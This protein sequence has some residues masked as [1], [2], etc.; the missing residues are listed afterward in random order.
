MKKLFLLKTWLLLCALIVGSGTM[1][2]TTSTLTFTKAC[3]GSG[4]ADDKTAWT[5]TS[6]AAESDYSSTKGIHYGTSKV[7]VSYLNLTTSG[8]SGTITQIVVNASGASG[9]SAKLNVTVGGNAFGSEQSL[10]SNATNYTLT[11]SASGTIVVAVTQSSAKKALYVKSITVTYSTGTPVVSA[12][13]SLSTTD[14]SINQ[15]DGVVSLSS[16]TLAEGLTNAPT[17]SWT[18][19]SSIPEGIITEIDGDNTGFLYS[20]GATTGT[21]VIKLAVTTTEEGYTNF[22]KT[23]DVNVINPSALVA[24]TITESTSFLGS[25]YSVMSTTTEGG[26]IKYST[27]GGANWLDYPG[28]DGILITETT[29]ITAKV[30]KDADESETVEATYT[31]IPYYENIAALNALEDY[32]GETEYV[33]LTNA[34][35]VYA[36]GANVFIQDGTSADCGINLY[37]ATSFGLAEGDKING[38]VYGT[39]A[40]QYSA[41]SL[42]SVGFVEG[43]TKESGAELPE[44]TLTSSE[45]SENFFNYCNMRVALSNVVVVKSIS[46][47]T[48]STDEGFEVYN[49]SEKDMTANTSYR[50]KG[51]CQIYSGNNRIRPL[52]NSDL[53]TVS[54]LSLDK[55][56]LSMTAGE[57]TTLVATYTPSNATVE[58]TT[59][60]SAVAT[61]ENG[62]IT[63]IASG[64]AT[65]TATIAD[66]EN[67]E[68][69][70]ATCE[71][72]IAPA[73]ATISSA[74][75]AATELL[76]GSTTTVTPTVVWNEDYTG[77]KVIT[78]QPSDETVISVDA[79]GNIK[80]LAAGTST[81][82]VAIADQPG[83]KGVSYVTNEITV[84]ALATP[85]FTPNGG[86][87]IGSTSVEIASTDGDAVNIYYSLDGSDPATLYS[88]PI[89]VSVGQTVKAIAKNK[90]DETYTS[91]LATSE[92]FTEATT[93]IELGTS[94]IVIQDF[95]ALTGTYSDNNGERSIGGY[96]WNVNQCINLNNKNEILQLRSGSGYISTYVTNQLG[97]VLTIAH[98]DSNIA[99]V[100][101]GGNTITPNEDSGNTRTYTIT[102]TSGELKIK[103]NGAVTKISSI[104]LTPKSATFSIAE[105]CTDGEKYYGTYSNSK[106]FVVP[107]GLT[108]S[109][110]SASNTGTLTVTDYETGDIV[111]ANTGVMVS[112]TTAG[113]KTV[114]LTTAA[115]EAKTAN[116]MLKPSGDAGITAEAMATAAPSCKYYR[117]TMHN[118]TQIGY[119]WGAAEGAAFAVTANKAYLAVPT[120]AGARESFW[121]DNGTT[122][123]K[124]V[125]K[126]AID[127]AV[128]NLSG[129]RV[130]N[131]TKGLYIVNGRKVVIK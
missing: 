23:F 116:N 6:D 86:K 9:T 128:Y 93:K 118:G 5:V 49:N 34:V 40:S 10:T 109:E 105:A 75:I 72:T 98:D 29:T 3:G 102:S 81:I 36:S 71:V 1:W 106:A 101:Y 42:K 103:E 123:I 7:A 30:V 8:I 87:I 65:I 95:S 117:L 99:A 63:A 127:G 96:N 38:Y 108:V 44:A 112:A 55:T 39:Y 82:T 60:N 62:T 51:V 28:G 14:L 59:T 53:V 61:V 70:I 47:S 43:W 41:P 68:G 19:E 64:S 67:F 115:G 35:V 121:F 80:A 73:I 74:T 125:S 120:G 21:A 46:G 25:M 52:H 114:V 54:T 113:E 90:V 15:A 79:E 131:P 111:P 129:Q 110:I 107:A 12:I 33:K 76:A 31:S 56:A 24:P 45:L 48:G 20:T 100:T 37:Q 97:F 2:G 22:E 130:E 57:E 83:F 88:T 66:A 77:E 89:I 4:T 18:V 13:G 124:Q 119:W 27:D 17:Y 58:W 126:K 32:T 122:G 26:I 85:T 78:Y 50:L 84:S 16:L 92:A 69:S 94:E 104:T 91:A 11:G